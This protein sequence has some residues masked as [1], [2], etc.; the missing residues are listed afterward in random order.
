MRSVI[1]AVCALALL[2]AVAGGAL[3]QTD[4]GNLVFM[5]TAAFATTSG[6]GST[7]VFNLSPRAYYFVADQVGV[8]GRLGFV[9][10]STSGLS[11]TTSIAFGPDAVY[12]FA[13]PSENLLPFAGLGLFFTH[14]DIGDFSSNGFTFSLHGGLAYLLK[15]HLSIFPEMSVDM[16]TQDSNSSTMVMLGVG[17]AGFLY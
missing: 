12:F 17:L 4:K 3:A 7:T 13:T 11:T 9:T 6:D 8:G 10:S 1:M 2:T 16:A 15:E 14:T 5:G